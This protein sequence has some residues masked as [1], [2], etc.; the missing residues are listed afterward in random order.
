MTSIFPRCSIRRDSSSRSPPSAAYLRVNA[1][2][3]PPA[4]ILTGKGDDYYNA[5]SIERWRHNI[6]L[7]RDISAEVVYKGYLF[8][9]GLHCTL[10][11]ITERR[12]QK[13][14]GRKGPVAVL[15]QRMF[16][17]IGNPTK[18]FPAFQQPDAG[19]RLPFRTLTVVTTQTPDIVDPYDITSGADDN[20]IY[21]NGRIDFGAAEGTRHRLLAAH[22]QTPRRR[23]EVRSA[24]RRQYP[25]APAADLRRQRRGQQQGRGRS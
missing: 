18:N 15:R 24:G 9:I 16:L 1:S 8:P 3:D 5:L 14:D 17:R 19:R 21:S 12:F 10:I 25:D 11:K 2:F 4:S 23:G 6:V 20:G 7:G 22:Q 13:V